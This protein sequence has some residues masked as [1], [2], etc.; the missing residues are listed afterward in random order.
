MN[1]ATKPVIFCHGLSIWAQQKSIVFLCATINEEV[2]IKIKKK[3]IADYNSV[4][5]KKYLGI[6]QTQYM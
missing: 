6:H 3:I 2:D 4:K 1:K 5:T